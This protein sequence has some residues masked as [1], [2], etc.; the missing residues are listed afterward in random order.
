MTVAS[1]WQYLESL[2]NLSLVDSLEM[3]SS[4]GGD[5]QEDVN[6][7]SDDEKNEAGEEEF[8]LP[9]K[10]FQGVVA[11]MKSRGEFGRKSNRPTQSLSLVNFTKV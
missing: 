11:E 1:I 4:S 8:S 10:E 2:Y 9:R 6:E 7:E 3:P 5:D